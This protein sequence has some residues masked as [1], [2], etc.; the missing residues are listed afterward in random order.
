MTDVKCSSFRISI[1]FTFW[2]L[3]KSGLEIGM[4]GVVPPP[5][6]HQLAITMVSRRSRNSLLYLQIA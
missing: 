5:S 2:A 1:D 3:P 6:S 4:F